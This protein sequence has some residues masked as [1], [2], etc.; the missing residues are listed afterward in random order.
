MLNITV[1]TG[2]LV[3]SPELRTTQQ[4]I[5]VAS[6]RLAVQ[7]DFTKDG[8]RETDFFDVVAWR[9]TAEFV[10]NYFHKG[11]MITAVGRLQNRAWKDKHDQN[12]VSAELIADKAYFAGSKSKGADSVNPLDF[13]EMDE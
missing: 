2:R 10:S 7:R 9:G 4:G 6:L 12:R 5:P 1:M 8:D 3:E 11:D 13:D